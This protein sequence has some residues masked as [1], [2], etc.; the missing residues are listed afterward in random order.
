MNI[1]RT[2]RS[3]PPRTQCPPAESSLFSTFSKQRGKNSTELA[4]IPK[5]SSHARRMSAVT[6]SN[7]MGHIKFPSRLRLCFDFAPLSMASWI[8]S[9]YNTSLEL[10]AGFVTKCP[11]VKTKKKLCVFMSSSF[12]IGSWHVSCRYFATVRNEK[13]ATQGCSVG[14]GGL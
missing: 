7:T 8:S 13:L 10:S 2:Q 1:R 5:G 12:S 3:T 14:N 9:C 6:S 11:Y 4:A